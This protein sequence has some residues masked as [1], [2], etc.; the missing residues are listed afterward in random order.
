MQDS[1]FLKSSIDKKRK[2][3]EQEKKRW[4]SG[5]KKKEDIPLLE[6]TRQVVDMTI[7]KHSE[8][9]KVITSQEAASAMLTTG[10]LEEVRYDSGRHLI[11]PTEIRG[12]CKHCKDKMGKEKRT[13]YRCE[14]CNVALHA[15]CFAPFHTPEEAS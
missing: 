15:D 7:L 8:G 5:E 1:S 12:V 10:T 3:R 6:F 2:E 9:S 11:I 14:R 13:V 4:R